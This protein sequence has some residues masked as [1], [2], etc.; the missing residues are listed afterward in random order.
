MKLAF[1]TTSLHNDN[2]N[3]GTGTYTNLLLETLNKNK[4]SSLEIIEFTKEAP[5][6]TDIIHY[7][8]F[9]PFFLTLPLIKSKPT[10]VTVHDLIPLKFPDKFP[11]GIRGEIKWQIQKYSLLQ[12]QAIIT[13]SKSSASDISSITGFAK[14]KIYTIPL[15]ANKIYKQITDKAKLDSIKNKYKL[16]DNFILYVGDVNWNKNIKGLLGAL[17]KIVT[18]HSGEEQ[19]D[20]SRIKNRFWTSQN[21]EIKLVLVG[22]SFLNTTLPEVVDINKLIEQLDISSSVIKLG[23]VTEDDLA[24]IYNLAKVY[25]QPSF[26]EGF[27][28]PVLEALSCSCSVTCSSTSSLPEVGGDA[29]LYF[30]PNNT[31]DMAEKISTILNYDTMTYHSR[32]KQGL[33]QAQKFSW[34]KTAQETIKV[35]EKILQS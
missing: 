12:S 19:S 16:P 9:D 15:A 7:P 21:D 1:N 14:D 26:Y 6:E 30:D 25:V 29:V 17:E 3:R 4:P 20:D 32:V 18:R 33:A 23:F 24:V 13:D 22:K 28:L 27:G 34:E 11:R 8:F 5:K 31:E 10:V 35:Y 2:I